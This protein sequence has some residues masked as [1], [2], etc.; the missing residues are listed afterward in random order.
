ME[1][2]VVNEATIKA[3]SE[4]PHARA[5]KTIDETIETIKKDLVGVVDNTMLTVTKEKA[6]RVI[7][8]KPT[9]PKNLLQATRDVNK[10]FDVYKHFKDAVKSYLIGRGQEYFLICHD[11]VRVLDDYNPKLGL[12]WSVDPDV[13]DE[14]LNKY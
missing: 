13:I 11:V 9:M 10:D 7:T 3:L 12:H 14:V 6:A 2:A 5:L 4:A 8:S 1:S